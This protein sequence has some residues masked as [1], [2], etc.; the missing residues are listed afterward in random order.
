M[1]DIKLV[2]NRQAK[3][4]I[5]SL[6]EALLDLMEEQPYHKISVTDLSE[7]SGLTRSTFYAHFQTK[8]EL[9]ESIL[10]EILDQF[11]GYLYERDVNNPDSES[12]LEINIKFFKIWKEYAETINLLRAIDID[13][14]LIKKFKVYWLEHSQKH[15]ALQNPGW[16][17]ALGEY[18]A[19]Y[20]SYSFVG[21]LRQWVSNEMK[22]SPE[23]MGRLLY[24]LT[25][26][27]VLKKVYD[28][29]NH[30]IK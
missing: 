2:R 1:S 30:E 29:F 17:L 19:N 8:D 18:L 15:L 12:D 14:L 27:P 21:I 28:K 4:S 7:R 26:P 20:L 24:Q 6:Q 22:E 10:E 25:G 3:R 9:L 16:P 5:I 23:V 11:F 13:C